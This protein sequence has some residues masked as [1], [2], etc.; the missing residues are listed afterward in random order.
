[1]WLLALLLL[2][3][4]PA[5]DAASAGCLLLL[6]DRGH[7]IT[8]S[9]EVCFQL[10]LRAD[11]ARVTGGVAELPSAE[12]RLVRIEG[13]LHGPRSV[14]REELAAAGDASLSVKVP[15]KA[16]LRIEGGPHPPPTLSL[17]PVDDESFRRAAFRAAMPP[18]RVVRVPAGEWLASLS[19]PGS[20]P[21][22]HLLSL[23]PAAPAR[24]RYRERRGWSAVVR[25]RAAATDRPV[26]G[27]TVV[28]RGAAG[29][30]RGEERKAM[31]G[32]HGLALFSGLDHALATATAHHPLYV[33]FELSG[34]VTSPGTF[35]F[36]E[37]RLAAGGGFRALVLRDDGPARAARCRL[38]DLDREMVGE[39]R[40]E[41][42]VFEEFTSAAGRCGTDA[43]LAPQ[44]YVLQVSLPGE[45]ASHESALEVRAGETTEVRVE[46]TPIRLSGRVTLGGRPA[47]GWR[48]EVSRSRSAASSGSNLEPVLEAVTAEDGT[49][50]A[51][52]WTPGDYTLMPLSPAGTPSVAFHSVYLENAEE[53]FDLDVPASAVR[54]TVTDEGGAPLRGAR[55]TLREARM[56]R[57]A[58][59]GA[60]GEFALPVESAG[61]ATLHAFKPGYVLPEPV[62]VI[63]PEGGS[64]PP[65]RL[66]MRRSGLLRGTVRN[67]SGPI[68]G[69]WVATRAEAPPGASIRSAITRS[70]GQF[71]V[72]LAST[73]GRL[74]FGGPGCA[75]AVR[76]IPAAEEAV[77]AACPELPAALVVHVRDADG[78]PVPHVA[79]RL[80][81]GG[82]VLPHAVLVNHLTT[83]GVP[84]ESDGSGRLALVAL[85]PGSYDLFLADRSSEESIVQGS[86]SGYLGTVELTPLAVTELEVA[87]PPR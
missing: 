53:T 60:A 80:R 64:P 81:H 5:T 82:T 78:R 20:A 56:V 55:V 17:Y 71:E 45:P 70:D 37:A 41:R 36:E 57:V 40:N 19:R 66:R 24:L 43:G 28:I 10:A 16:L 32:A 26:P 9:I 8:T 44:S 51:V 58:D 74:F 7:T 21:D 35:A 22:L 14:R 15:R 86:P 67:A 49:Y 52:L 12:F 79:A 72:E 38:L 85:E 68:A 50:D 61:S 47:A 2:A 23:E 48:V 31:T 62:E 4:E 11:C 6:D 87:L 73:P 34:I 18:E 63:V 42:V 3:R 27:A 46:L 30:A 1:M 54:G 76:P 25:C 84:A 29:F 33:P 83:F 59:T 65:V 13:D 69:A 39:R 75:L 77:T